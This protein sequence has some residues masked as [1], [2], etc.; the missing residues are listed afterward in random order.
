MNIEKHVTTFSMISLDL[1]ITV[2]GTAVLKC[3]G[4]KSS[5]GILKTIIGY[6][7]PA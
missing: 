6:L 7:V 1:S 4:L 3:L 2:N 5:I